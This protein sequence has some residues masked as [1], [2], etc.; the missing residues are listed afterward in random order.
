MLFVPALAGFQ[1]LA[2]PALEG[3][4][5]YQVF[6]DHADDWIGTYQKNDDYDAPEYTTHAEIS[7]I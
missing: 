6:H 2:R 4:P 7:S 1:K 5:S 3:V